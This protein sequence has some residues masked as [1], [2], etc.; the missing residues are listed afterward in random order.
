MI[1]WIC[2]G[3]DPDCKRC[4]EAPMLQLRLSHE[5]AQLIQA[6][7]ADAMDVLQGEE[8]EMAEAIIIRLTVAADQP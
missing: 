6:T 1:C 3:M 8:R 5:E 4:G 2:D 7:L